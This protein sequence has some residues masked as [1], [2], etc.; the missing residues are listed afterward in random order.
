MWFSIYGHNK[1]LGKEEIL[2]RPNFAPN[3][4]LEVQQAIEK[5]S[6]E[7]IEKLRKNLQNL[8]KASFSS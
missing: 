8:E 5:L 7:D 3:F 2:R 6:Q 4:C 1:E